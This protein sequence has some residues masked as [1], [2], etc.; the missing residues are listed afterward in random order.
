MLN[1]VPDVLITETAN[2][3][4]KHEIQI[5]ISGRPEYKPTWCI[6]DHFHRTW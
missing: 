2:D 3:K 5:G 1:G 4:T 6:S